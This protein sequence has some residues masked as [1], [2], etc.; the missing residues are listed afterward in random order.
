M[1]LIGLPRLKM[2]AGCDQVK[3]VLFGQC[4]KFHKSR[5]WKLLVR[6]HVSHH[7]LSKSIDIIA[8]LGGPLRERQA[9]AGERR[10][11]GD[12]AR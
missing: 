6:Q 10:R 8:A 11:S 12:H 9:S 5:N 4:T 2:I 3:A 1:T 7:V